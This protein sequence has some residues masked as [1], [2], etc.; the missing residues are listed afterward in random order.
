MRPLRASLLAAWDFVVGDD[1][2]TAV[3]VVVA[4]GLTAGIQET[5]VAAWWVPPA[6]VLA[7]LWFSIRRAMR[8]K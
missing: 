2:P 5:G 6:A 8:L 1:W 4:L 7:L 3:G